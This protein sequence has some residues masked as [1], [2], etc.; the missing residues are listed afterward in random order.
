MFVA[1]F[2]AYANL[3][4]GSEKQKPPVTPRSLRFGQT[5]AEPSHQPQESNEAPVPNSNQTD[6][7]SSDCNAVSRESENWNSREHEEDEVSDDEVY[8]VSDDEVCDGSNENTENG[9]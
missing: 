9:S 3:L 1:A 7:V 6:E 5:V 2:T 4:P 8:E